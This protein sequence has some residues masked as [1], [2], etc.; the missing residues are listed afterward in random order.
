MD[1]ASD[2]S[3]SSSSPSPCSSLGFELLLVLSFFGFWVRL[4]ASLSQSLAPCREEVGYDG[5]WACVVVV[6]GV[7]VGWG[8]EMTGPVVDSRALHFWPG[9][10]LRREI[11]I[12]VEKTETLEVEGSMGA[13]R[14]SRVKSYSAPEGRGN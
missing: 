11:S 3:P 10:F 5:A 8:V 6:V 13:K 9:V 14:G 2:A 1:S 7:T 12:F 4:E